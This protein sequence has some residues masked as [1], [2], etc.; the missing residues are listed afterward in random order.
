MGFSGQEYSGGLPC[1][2][3]GYLLNPGIEPTSPASPALQAGFL[4]TEPPGKPISTLSPPKP[5]FH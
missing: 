5:C 3:P 1:P 4:P 2:P